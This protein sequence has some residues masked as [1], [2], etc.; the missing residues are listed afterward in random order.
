MKIT[1]VRGW[2]LIDCTFM[3]V[4][5]EQMRFEDFRWPQVAGYVIHNVAAWQQEQRNARKYGFR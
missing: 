5:I 4:S 2:V 1:R 3:G